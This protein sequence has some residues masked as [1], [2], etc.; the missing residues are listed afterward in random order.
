MTVFKQEL[1]LLRT[2]RSSSHRHEEDYD[3]K[4]RGI[5]RKKIR[6]RNLQQRIIIGASV[7]IL[8]GELVVLLL[9]E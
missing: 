3:L 9:E 6:K 4:K 1:L 8:G 5:T 7:L 2:S